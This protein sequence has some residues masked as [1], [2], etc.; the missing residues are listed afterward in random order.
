[1]TDKELIKD[2]K[3]KKRNIANKDNW[4]QK[5]KFV[6]NGDAIAQSAAHGLFAGGSLSLERVE[7][8]VKIIQRAETGKVGAKRIK[9]LDYLLEYS[10]T[11]LTQEQ[12]ANALHCCRK[13]LY[14]HRRHMIEAYKKK[15]K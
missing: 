13:T 7:S 11:R 6:R 9:T 8:A 3:R 2:W 5:Q 12:M 4:R 15:K 10:G 14:N 1:M